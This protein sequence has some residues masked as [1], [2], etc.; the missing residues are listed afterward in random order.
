LKAPDSLGGL[1]VVHL[2]AYLS[3]YISGTVEMLTCKCGGYIGKGVLTGSRERWWCSA[4]GRYEIMYR[5]K[6]GKQE[7]VPDNKEV[8][9]EETC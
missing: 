3:S 6:E 2:P 4:C 8:K 9:N 7:E 5:P 1:G